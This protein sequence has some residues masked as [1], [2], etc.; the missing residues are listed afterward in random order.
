M[1]ST[2]NAKNITGDLKLKTDEEIARRGNEDQ[3]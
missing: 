2:E 1:V 3:P